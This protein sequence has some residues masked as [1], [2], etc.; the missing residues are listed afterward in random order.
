MHISRNS[1]KDSFQV[2]LG[3]KIPYTTSERLNSED[4]SR[5]HSYFEDGK[6]PE[7]NLVLPDKILNG[8][9]QLNKIHHAG[10][11]IFESFETNLKIH[12]YLELL[13]PKKEDDFQDCLKEILAGISGIKGTGISG[14]MKLSYKDTRFF[15]KVNRLKDQFAPI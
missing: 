8:L 10:C 7:E 1:S 4:K 6:D 12:S 3:L 14:F 9:R 13:N 5:V 15:P 11:I 2:P